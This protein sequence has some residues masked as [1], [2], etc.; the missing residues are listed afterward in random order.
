MRIALIGT[1]RMGSAVESLLAAH[2][3]TLVA[4][5]NSNNPLSST[6]QLESADVAIDFSLPL[7]APRHIDVCLESRVP[8]VVGTTGWHQELSR[9]RSKVTRADGALL[10]SP[11]F[12]LGVQLLTQAVSTL[13]ELL[14]QLPD[15]DVAIH[16]VHHTGKLDRPSGTAIKLAE[17]IID[18][19]H[20]KSEWGEA[21]EVSPEI[22]E[23]SSSRT[24]TVYG[25]HSIRIDGPA[26]QITLTHE[27][28]SRTGFALGAL[29]AA[30]WLP[31]RTGLFTLEDMLTDWVGK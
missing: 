6:A 4:R 16:E 2:G 21:G 3:H 29:K 31:G 17:T 24:G 5:F 20:R 9:I 30:E 8:V 7:L 15:Y 11:N 10:Y 18:R 12:S 23:V 28:K 26:D 22:L 13:S 19:L 27:A 25:R 14:N 1:G